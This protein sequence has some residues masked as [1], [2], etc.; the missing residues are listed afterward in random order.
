MFQIRW[1]LN[2]WVSPSK[3]WLVA[4]KIQ[5]PWMPIAAPCIQPPSRSILHFRGSNCK[6]ATVSTYYRTETQTFPCFSNYISRYAQQFVGQQ[7]HEANLQT[8]CLTD[9]SA[10]SHFGHSKPSDGPRAIGCSS[11]KHT[12]L[13][14]SSSST[15]HGH[16]LCQ[17]PPPPRF[18]ARKLTVPSINR[19]S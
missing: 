19:A 6:F 17:P 18:Q 13:C 9:S 10:A 15:T 11:L 12:S 8:S 2:H 3:M 5:A 1:P 7:P 16:R 4:F 14:F